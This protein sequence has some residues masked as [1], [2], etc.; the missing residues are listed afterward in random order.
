MIDHRRATPDYVLTDSQWRTMYSI[1]NNTASSTTNAG[2]TIG[3]VYGLDAVD[4]AEE[5][6]KRKRRE[7]LLSA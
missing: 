1:A 3:N 6:M 7:E 5:I 2:I 4:V